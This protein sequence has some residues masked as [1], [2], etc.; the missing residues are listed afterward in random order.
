MI[1]SFAQVCW[2]W[3]WIVSRRK[4]K[5]QRWSRKA[6][7]RCWIFWWERLPSAI[8][9]VSS[10]SVW[11]PPR[12]LWHSDAPILDAC[13]RQ[14]ETAPYSK[15]SK[16]CLNT[17]TTRPDTRPPVADRWAGA[18]MRFSHLSTQSLW[19]DGRTDERTDTSF[20]QSRGSRLK[21]SNETHRFTIRKFR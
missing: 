4:D 7:R 10:F 14:F 19:T 12:P 1:E 6:T 5:S 21:T 17:V 9:G 16:A 13:P 20:F 18:E 3:L 15:H 11:I 2:Q 8:E